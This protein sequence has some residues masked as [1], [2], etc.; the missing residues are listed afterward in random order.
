MFDWFRDRRARTY[1]RGLEVGI[2]VKITQKLGMDS[3]KA[4]YAKF[5][6]SARKVGM[7]V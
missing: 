3:Q 5:L 2:L 6:E 1:P 7:K 4:Q